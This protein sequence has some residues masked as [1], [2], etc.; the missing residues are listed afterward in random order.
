MIKGR[1]AAV[2]NSTFANTAVTPYTRIAR[3]GRPL[4]SRVLLVIEMDRSTRQGRD[5]LLEPTRVTL[6][7]QVAKAGEADYGGI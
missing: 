5:H 6:R 7:S 2:N 3:K 1:P 4:G